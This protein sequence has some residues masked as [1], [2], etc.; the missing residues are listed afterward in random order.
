[1][2]TEPRLFVGEFLATI[3]SEH[4]LTLPQK[5]QLGLPAE[6]SSLWMLAKER[7]GAL[8]IWSST[9]SQSRVDS[10]VVRMAARLQ[11]RMTPTQL[12]D[13]Q[14]L[15][16]LL[17]ART[18]EV[19]IS[20]KGRLTIPAECRDFLGIKVPGNCVIVGAGPAIEIWQ[21]DTWQEYLK[22]EINNFGSLLEKLAT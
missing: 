7:P 22:Q 19:K 5:F 18:A 8:S 10:E 6:Q 17:S 12:G 1:M 13:N 20:P 3:D 11:G 16:R 21:P 9:E 2:N 4:R 15:M 14:R